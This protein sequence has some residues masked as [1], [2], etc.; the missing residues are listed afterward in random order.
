M[1]VMVGTGVGASHGILMKGGETLEVASKA[2][3]VLFDKTGTLTRGKPAVT[4]FTRLASDEFLRSL[5]SRQSM[6]NLHMS[7]DDFLIW[8]L[9]SL[10]RNSEHVLAT[11]IVKFTEEKI[12][13]M[14]RWKPLAQ[15]TDFVAMTGRGASGLINDGI[16]VA[17]GNRSFAERENMIIPQEAEECTRTLESEGKTAI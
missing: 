15:P 2:N 13:D 3:V 12:D 4:D 9:G 5:M 1:G 17:I 7:T 14:L 16:K 11:A 6:D 10:E 8:L